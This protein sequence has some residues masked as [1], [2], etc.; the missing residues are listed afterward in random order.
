MGKTRKIAGVDE[1][2]RGPLAGPVF[3]AAVIL[4]PRK[5]IKDLNDSK[6]LTPEKREE[7]FLLIQERSQ[8]W[9]VGRAE[10]EEI[11]TINILQATLLA[12]QRAVLGLSIEPD[13]V[14]VDGNQRPNISFTT[15]LHIE[16]DKNFP[17]ISAA[18]IVAKVVRDQ[19]MIAMDKLYP[20]YGFAEHKG[21]STPS[22]CRALQELGVSKLHR[23]SFAPVRE[24]LE[25]TVLITS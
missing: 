12:M 11:D 6:L 21:Y 17:E 10:V 9:A 7:L 1:A 24:L 25:K 13:L 15:S 23:K 3:A 8:A 4:N 16:G 20:G 19:E 5:P 18:S 22:H 14:R 2:G